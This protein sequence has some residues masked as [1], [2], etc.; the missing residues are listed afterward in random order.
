MHFSLLG[1]DALSGPL[2]S[3]DEGLR[4]LIPTKGGSAEA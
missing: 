2:V 1:S 4:G 3:C